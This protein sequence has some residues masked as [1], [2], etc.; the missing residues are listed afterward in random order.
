MPDSLV[1]AA[2]RANRPEASAR[3]L[4]DDAWVDSSDGE[5]RDVTNPGT[6][7]V[8]DSVP[9]ATD[10]DVH[11][12]IAAAQRGK[13]NMR[14]LPAHQRAAI[15]SE[16]SRRLVEEREALAVLLARENGK[17]I[18]QTREEVSA[19][20]RIFQGFAEEAK[21]IFGRAM[22]MDAVPGLERHVALTVREPVGVVAAIVPFN[23]PVELYAHKAAAALAAGNAVIGKPPSEC[24]LTLLRLAAI[25]QAAG[26]PSGGHQMITGQ[27]SRIGTILASDPGVQLI[28]LTG[29]V[30]VGVE[31]SRVAAS[32]LKT[33]LTELGGNDAFIVC[34]D[35]DV[36]RAADAIVLGRL[37]RGNGQIC[38]AVKRVFAHESVADE[39]GRRLTEQ[40]RG[41]QVGDALDESTDVGPLIT[42]AAAE[43]VEASIAEAVKAGARLTTGGTRRGAFVEPT[44]LLDVAQ[45][46]IAF[47]SEIFGPV[48]PVVPFATI[49]EAIAMA[50]DSPY[51]LQA[52]VFTRD[53]SNA[54]D[55]ASRLEA[56]GVIV[57][58]S[59]AL[60]AENLPF[61]GVKLSGHGR[62]GIHDTLDEMTVQKVILF[63]DVLASSGEH[64]DRTST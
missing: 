7:E 30:E 63:H 23:Y 25:M 35:A 16:I 50:N 38:C 64:D 45:D 37:A 24:P 41:L 40:A 15:L 56:G 60:R 22:P 12:A 14:R 57:N 51:G 9:V 1:A 36:A 20:A 44:V 2:T 27:G 43:R 11:R 21:R 32:S 39:L 4:I 34:A 17:P 62:E 47:R 54:F 55:I 58:W 48:V 6:G 46:A 3:M 42:E 33:V 31:L 49:D 5:H 18:R 26:L 19:A 61:G 8:I 29:S 59:S 52:A 28:S 53:V 10:E 13:V